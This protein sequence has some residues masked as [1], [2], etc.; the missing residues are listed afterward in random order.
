MPMASSWKLETTLRR[1][2][3]LGSMPFPFFAGQALEPVN[4]LAVALTIRVVHRGEHIPL[5]GQLKRDDGEGQRDARRR[6]SKNNP[7]T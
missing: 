5:P 2:K 7:L 6:L 3:S 4:R 1:K